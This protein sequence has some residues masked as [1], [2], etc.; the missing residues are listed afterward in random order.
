VAAGDTATLESQGALLLA[1]HAGKLLEARWF[2]DEVDGRTRSSARL[3]G[4]ERPS[5]LEA[6][7]DEAAAVSKTLKRRRTT[8]RCSLY[9]LYKQAGSGDVSERRRARHDQPRQVRC[10]G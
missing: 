9:S 8:T 7:F 1:F 4:G 3:I 2:A 5:Q 10:V 6:A